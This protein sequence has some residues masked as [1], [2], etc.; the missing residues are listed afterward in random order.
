MNNSFVY[1]WTDHKTNML[2]IGSHKGTENDGYVCSRKWMMEE[3]NVRPQDFTRQIIA[4]GTFEDIRK[5]EA[6]LLDTLNVKMDDQF[7]NQDNGNGNFYLKHKTEEH[8]RK[9][10][11]YFKG[12]PRGPLS[13]ETKAK[14][15]KPKSAE[16]R[17]K[18]KGNQN[19]KGVIKTPEQIEAV[20]QKVLGVKRSEQASINASLGNKKRF[21]D[22]ENRRKQSEA[23]KKSWETRKRNIN[24]NR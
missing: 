14:M 21:A 22:P 20:R 7:Y 23:I 18:L 3:Y 11:E 2:Y 9:L 5:L 24:V 15:R 8:K 1:C 6:I 4:N 17:E 19:A 12:R 13:E 10:S 16:H